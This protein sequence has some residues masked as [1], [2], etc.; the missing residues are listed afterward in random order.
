MGGSILR[1]PFEGKTYPNIRTLV[2]Q[3]YCHHILACCPNLR[4]LWCIRDDGKKLL[5]PILERCKA[6]EEVRGFDL[7]EKHLQSMSYLCI[8]MESSLL[9]CLPELINA[10]PNLRVFEVTLDN[11]EVH[12]WF[13]L[14]GTLLL[15]I[16]FTAKLVLKH[17]HKW[18]KLAAVVLRQGRGPESPDSPGYSKF[19][20]CIRAIKSRLESLPKSEVRNQDV[21]LLYE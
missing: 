3:G 13:C 18:K 12:V 17:L 6:L 14:A 5:S 11:Y 21:C 2:I 1:N 8:P 10:T 19:Q 20:T 15:K 7:E 4:T 16:K 9:T